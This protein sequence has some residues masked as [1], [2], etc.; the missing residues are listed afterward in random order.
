MIGDESLGFVFIHLPVPHPGGFYDRRTGAL[1]VNGS[2]LDNL[3]LADEALGQLLQWIDETPPVKETTVI[4]SSDHSWRVGMWKMSPMW[5]DEDERV[6]QG[7]FD[8]RPVLMV[9]FPGSESGQKT[10]RHFRSCGLMG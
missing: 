6:S 1:G 10:R 8:P 7:R 4:V 9:R 3:V 5:T 2:Y